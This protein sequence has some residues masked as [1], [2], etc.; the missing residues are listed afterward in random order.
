MPSRSLGAAVLLLVVLATSTYFVSFASVKSH[1]QKSKLAKQLYTRSA[2]S[3]Q[4][5]DSLLPRRYVYKTWGSWWRAVVSGGSAQ[6]TEGHVEFL[7]C[8]NTPPLSPALGGTLGA[9]VAPNITWSSQAHVP[10]GNNTFIQTN[11]KCC[12]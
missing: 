12:R 11:G 7:H 5:D 6:Y 2:I 9:F 10:I 8:P 3:G 4:N 1:H